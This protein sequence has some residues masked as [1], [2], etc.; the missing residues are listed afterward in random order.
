MI[1]INKWNI[2]GKK[3]EKVKHF[4]RAWML[5]NIKNN[6]I[7]IDIWYYKIFCLFSITFLYLKLK[8]KYI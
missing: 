6:L 2:K 4:S 5:K 1:I 3:I 7:N 8:L